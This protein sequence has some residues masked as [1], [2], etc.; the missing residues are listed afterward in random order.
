MEPVTPEVQVAFFENHGKVLDGWDT[1][2]WCHLPGSKLG[3]VTYRMCDCGV[4]GS[5][6]LGSLP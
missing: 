4:A 5:F 3:S 1:R 2:F 6:S